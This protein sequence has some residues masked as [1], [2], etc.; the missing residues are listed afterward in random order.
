[1]DGVGYSLNPFGATMA[2]GGALLYAASLWLL[3][4]KGLDR[5]GRPAGPFRTCIALVIFGAVLLIVGL[6]VA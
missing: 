2:V 3:V 4:W 1:M 5:S 6:S